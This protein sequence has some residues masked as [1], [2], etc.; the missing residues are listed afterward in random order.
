MA[1]T[2]A[3]DLPHDPTAAVEAAAAELPPE[4]VAQTFGEYARAYAAA[5]GPNQALVDKWLEFLAK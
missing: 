5:K 4:L 3:P 1:R 2:E